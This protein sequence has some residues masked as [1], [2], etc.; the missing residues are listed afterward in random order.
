PGPP[1]R[2]RDRSPQALPRR[3]PGSRR[4][5]RRAT[6][7]LPRAGRSRP[8][9]LVAG[10]SGRPAGAAAKAIPI[11]ARRA[12]PP[13]H[14]IRVAWRSTT[15]A[16]PHALF[17]RHPGPTRRRARPRPAGRPTAPGVH[18]DPRRGRVRRTRPP[19]RTDGA[20]DL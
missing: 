18:I 12:V 8:V 4:R 17:R 13:P 1:P 3:D 6:D 11:P 9:E 14:T 20:G 10:V 16:T 7:P 2:P 15:E 19:S 5:R